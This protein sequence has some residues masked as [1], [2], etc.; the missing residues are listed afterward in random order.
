MIPFIMG[1]AFLGIHGMP[2]AGLPGMLVH[3]MAATDVE[4]YHEYRCAAHYC[5]SA[6]CVHGWRIVS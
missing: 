6:G 1:F 2:C 4:R 3:Q 5:I